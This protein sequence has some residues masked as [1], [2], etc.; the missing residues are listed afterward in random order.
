MKKSAKQSTTVFIM[1]AVTIVLLLLILAS[2]LVLFWMNILVSKANSDRYSLT[3]NA[4]LFMNSSAY[5]TD[6][7][8]AY[9]STGNNV[10]YDN[11]WN[12]V[13]NLKNRELGIEAMKKIGITQEEQKKIDDM[14]SLSNK[15]VPLEEKAMDNVKQGDTKSAINYVYGEDY[16]NEITEISK[17]KAE[18]LSMLDKRTE[19]RIKNLENLNILI[20]IL[21][22]F[23][24]II[25]I[26]LQ[27]INNLFIKKKVIKPIIAIEKVANEIANGNLSSS[28]DLEPDTS[29]IG[30]LTYGIIST[31]DTLKKYIYNISHNLSEMSI[32][33]M[34][35]DIDID[36]IGDFTPIKNSMQKII[37]SLNDTLIQ[38]NQASDQ[39]SSGSEQVSA[40]AQ[41]LSQGAT[42]QASSIEELSATIS[43]IAEKI[44]ENAKYTDKANLSAKN[45]SV[46][47]KN[48][49]IQ[50]KHMIEAMNNISSTSEEI[51]KIIKTIEDIAF[52]TNILALNA[53]VEAARAGAA[54]KGFA[55]VADEVRNLA[56]KSA[57]AVKN[58]TSLIDNSI[59]AVENGV[60]IANDTATSIDNIVKEV[61]NIAIGINAISEKSS[62]QAEAAEQI[63]LAIDQI[64]AVVQTN[65]ATAEESAASSEELSGQAAIL[66]DLVKQF[67]LKKFG[68]NLN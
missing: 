6:E 40:G 8:R 23:E 52:Q 12:E 54:G 24:I 7:V 14:S 67:K 43:E 53:A 55:V 33:N 42:E 36:Y 49:S 25:I 38:I 56:A 15:L 63:T 44:R 50:M 18:F 28:F 31:K 61:E 27:V 21:L 11:Y 46:E 30:M 60:K 51:G 57:E 45:T 4:N 16:E 35:L 58:T 9:A 47:M 17:I 22:I 68:T 13:D 26:F 19:L 10:H 39:V 1:N 32:G 65:S 3:Q 5:L 34:N 62:E 66:K 59:Q 29:E 37:S 2:S 64:S 41:A 20:Q 48:G